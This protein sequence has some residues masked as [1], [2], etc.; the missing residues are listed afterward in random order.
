M[1]VLSITGWGLLVIAAT[2]AFALILIRH[3]RRPTWL[4]IAVALVCGTVV[5]VEGTPAPGIAWAMAWYLN[6]SHRVDLENVSFALTVRQRTDVVSIA[7][8]GG[9]TEAALPNQYELPDGY[10]G[11]SIDGTVWVESDACGAVV[12]FATITGFSPDPYGGVE[13]AA[14][15]C[16]TV[17]DPLGSGAGHARPLV[18]NWY[19]I[20]AS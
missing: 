16:T 15:G 13:Y 19:W 14:P 3:K 11:L 4:F 17:D 5:F 10:T 1:S 2:G 7:G 18:A 12:F 20:D 6:P 9:L 8:R